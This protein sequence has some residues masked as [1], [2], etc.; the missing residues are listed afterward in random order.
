MH[1]KPALNYTAEPL[2]DELF[3]WHFTI[4]GPPETAFEGGRFHGR[5]V[6]PGDPELAPWLTLMSQARD[7]TGDP[8]S[9]WRALCVALIVHPDFYS[10]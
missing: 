5:M 3:E 6:A 4:A 7:A 9:S 8:A 1:R 10:Y 2:E